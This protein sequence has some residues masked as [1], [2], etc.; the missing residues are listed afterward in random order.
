M[1]G[2][3]RLGA[4]LLSSLIV[5]A[6]VSPAAAATGWSSPASQLRTSQGTGRVVVR[7][8]GAARHT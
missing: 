8:R 7:R 4:L 3:R 1:H 5:L 6:V 2:I